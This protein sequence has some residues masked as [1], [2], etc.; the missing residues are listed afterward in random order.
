M[1]IKSVSYILIGIAMLLGIWFIVGGGYLHESSRLSAQS[2]KEIQPFMAGI[3][4]PILVLAGTLLV[5][6]NLRNQTAQQ[7]ANNFFGL[8]NIHHKI[9]ENIS[10]EV[11]GIDLPGA[12]STGRELFDNLAFRIYVDY[13]RKDIKIVNKPGVECIKA[14]SDESFDDKKDLERL[15]AI[16]FYYFHAYHSSL[17]HYFR[18]LYHIVKFVDESKLHRKEKEGYIKILRAQLSNYEILLLAYN[19][20]SPYGASF[21]PLIEKY[22]LLKNLNWEDN[23]GKVYIKRIIDPEKWILEYPHL[24]A[25]RKR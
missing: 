3:V 14:F 20:L 1:S 13:I 22:K 5:F 11:D 12:K 2:A 23:L 4:A 8:I 25:S 19:G 18:N 16:Y 10:D 17:G 24:K 7:F 15:N 6:E 9:V 21:K